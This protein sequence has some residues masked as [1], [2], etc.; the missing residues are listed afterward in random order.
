MHLF[1]ICKNK[2]L[3]QKKN[4]KTVGMPP[5]FNNSHYRKSV[6]QQVQKQGTLYLSGDS[7]TDL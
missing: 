3:F 4:Q 7:I 5:L 2:S 1:C 6:G